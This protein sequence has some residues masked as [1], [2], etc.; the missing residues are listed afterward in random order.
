MI[1]FAHC[2]R[3][4][5]PN[6][7]LARLARLGRCAPRIGR[8]FAVTWL[9]SQSSLGAQPA[10]TAEPILL[11]N[12]QQIVALSNNIPA[13]RYKARFTAVVLYVSVPTK[14]CCATS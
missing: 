2:V 5:S 10:G 9:V 4:V 13:D 8:A 3:P 12:A 14:A 7:L 1:Q 11:T 6:G